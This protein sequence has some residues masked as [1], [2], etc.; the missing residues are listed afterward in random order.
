MGDTFEIEAIGE[1]IDQVKSSEVRMK[2]KEASSGCFKISHVRELCTSIE[3][4]TRI[5]DS[6]S[7]GT[8]GIFRSPGLVINASS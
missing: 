8:A 6:L 2:A 3:P 1:H 7:N 4:K 5:T